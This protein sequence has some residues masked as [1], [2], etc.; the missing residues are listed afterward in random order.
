[1][2]GALRRPSVRQREQ[3]RLPDCGYEDWV[4]E[5]D[6][7]SECPSAGPLDEPEGDDA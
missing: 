7:E 5:G 1:V 3:G 4:P 6:P 2:V